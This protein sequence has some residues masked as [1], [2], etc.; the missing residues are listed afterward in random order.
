MIILQSIFSQLK[1]YY[2]SRDQCCIQ[3]SVKTLICF[4]LTTWKSNIMTV[5]SRHTK[6]KWANNEYT[7]EVGC[8]T[9]FDFARIAHAMHV[10]ACNCVQ[11][12]LIFLCFTCQCTQKISLHANAGI[13]MR[14][15]VRIAHNSVHVQLR[16]MQT[17]ACI[18]HWTQFVQCTRNTQ[19][20]CVCIV[21]SCV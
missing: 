7:A 8:C 20:W 9:H 5:P 15:C 18:A 4:L 11:K 21:R 2:R 6:Q 12:F 10:F 3:R 19:L 17:V 14:Y 1:K 16:T 13:Y